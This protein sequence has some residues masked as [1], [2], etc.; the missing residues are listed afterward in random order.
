VQEI[1]AIDLF[2]GAGGF[3]EGARRAGCR[4]LWAANHWPA[5]V[6]C[7]SANHPDTQHVTQDLHQADWTTV[8]KHDL[9]LAS[10]ACQGHSRA[11]GKNRPH[12]DAA[13]STAWAVVS[14]LEYHRSPVAL[15]EN[16]PE[17]LK[18]ALYPAWEMA[19]RALGYSVAPH[20][21]DA[22]DFGVPQN[23]VRMFLVLTRSKHALYL[24]LPK[25][26]KYVPAAQIVDWNA[27]NWS[28]ID[29]PGR[30]ESTLERI[31][32]GRKEY[33]DRF[34]ISYYGGSMN[35]HSL[36]K[37]FGTI[38]TRDR[39]ALID[40]SRMRMLIIPESQAAMGFR[41]DYWLPDSHELALHLLGNA[42]PPPMATGL[43]NALKAAA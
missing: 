18:W 43:I 35:G 21:V 29:R 13:R 26:G 3:S 30:A 37:P 9:L 34:T 23:R 24:D 12:H 31:A 6:E 40:G 15:I 32:N 36:D 7:H 20:I 14:A 42:V 4:I 27:G 17:Y 1:D 8:P 25:P 39:H 41:P 5:A 10:P 28:P 19:V 33:G 2:A 16:V 22:A 11:R 38:T